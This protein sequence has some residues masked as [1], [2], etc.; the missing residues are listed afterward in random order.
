[1][2][3]KDLIDQLSPFKTGERVDILIQLMKENNIEL[4][5]DVDMLIRNAIKKMRVQVIM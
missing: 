4:T 3:I 5:P 2:S 1:M